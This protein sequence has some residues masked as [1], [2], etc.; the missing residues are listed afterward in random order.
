VSSFGISGTNAH[1]ILEEVPPSARDERAAADTDPVADGAVPLVVSAKTSEALRGQ[2]E[3]LRAWLTGAPEID[4]RG[5]ARAL[6]DSRA[7]LD[8]RGVVVGRDRE[9]LLAGLAALAAGAT[10]PHT[11]EA[12]AVPGAT[13]FLFT[14]GGAQRVGM[15]ADLYR[16][17]PVFATAL[18]EVCAEFDRHLGGSLREVM[19]TDAAGVLDRMDWMQPALFAFEVAMFRLLESYGLVPDVLAGHSLGELVAA[20]VSGIW[21]LADACVLVAARGRLMGAAPAGGAMLAAAVSET[22][23][24]SGRSTA[25]SRWCSRGTPTPSARCSG[26]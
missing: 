21:S 1:V 6:L 2:A 23:S 20:Y 17:F 9:E 16:A 22:G 11:V 3:R 25:P 7:L 5:V 8:R 19:F 26:G 4:S 13:A 24:R 14:G 12:Q 10:S 18:D 15:G